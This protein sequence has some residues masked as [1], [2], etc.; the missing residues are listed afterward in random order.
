MKRL[1]IITLA[2][3]MLF[4]CDN[5]DQVPEKTLR[6]NGTI[7]NGDTGQPMSEVKVKLKLSGMDVASKLLI[8]SWDSTTTDISG[9]YSF[10]KMFDRSKVYFNSY[11]IMPIIDYY[12]NCLGNTTEALPTGIVLEMQIDTLKINSDIKKICPIGQIKFIAKKMSVAMNDTLFFR[13]TLKTTS[14]D[15]ITPKQ[16]LT[17]PVSEIYFK[18]FTKNVSGVDFALTIKKEDGQII[19]TNQIVTLQPGTT[20]EL[21]IDY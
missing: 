21:K 15:I 20:K 16:Y 11:S 9:N 5:D 14:S 17:L 8:T 1:I 4:A 10:T 19:D 7:N 2:F 6:F 18:Y 13:P 12:E 3:T